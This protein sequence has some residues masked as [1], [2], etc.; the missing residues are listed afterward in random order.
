MANFF[1]SW[2]R[3]K[4]CYF[5]AGPKCL[6]G[7]GS[8]KKQR[9]FCFAPYIKWRTELYSS[10][11]IFYLWNNHCFIKLNACTIVGHLSSRYT[12]FYLY[13]IPFSLTAFIKTWPIVL[14]FSFYSLFS[15]V[16]LFFVCCF[17]F[18]ILH[19]LLYCFFL[20]PYF[21]HL[22]YVIYK[23]VLV[24][25]F[26]FEYLIC[27]YFYFYFCV[28]ICFCFFLLILLLFL[29]WYFVYEFCFCFSFCFTFGFLC[30][31]FDHFCC[32]LF[33]YFYCSVWFIFCFLI[34]VWFC[35]MLLYVFLVLN[36]FVFVYKFLFLFW[37][38]FLY[39][40][41]FLFSLF[42]QSIMY[43]ILLEF[44]NPNVYS[45]CFCF[46]LLLVFDFLYLHGCFSF[47]V[48][49]VLHHFLFL[50]SIFLCFSYAY[51]DFSFQLFFVS[52]CNFCLYCFDSFAWFVFTVF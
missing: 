4:W 13:S 7:E 45:C 44:L 10:C 40:I 19:L 24:L 47:L 5:S 16:F 52:I 31:I 17:Y 18:C 6:R 9:S 33:L 1:S 11:W 35:C 2:K 51:N 38:N 23:L 43:F 3:Q 14:H 39:A 15:F 50:I 21:L 8:R 37:H 32:L 42:L 20:F 41:I 34:S 30:T 36:I 46:L 27:F 49:N 12:D 25:V 29:L 28:C 48:C 22:F 26:C